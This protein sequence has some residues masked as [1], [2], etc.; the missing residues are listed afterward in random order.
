MQVITFGMDGSTTITIECVNGVH[1]D[2]YHLDKVSTYMHSGSC[3]S[4]LS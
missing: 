2:V 1:E 3:Q 4:S